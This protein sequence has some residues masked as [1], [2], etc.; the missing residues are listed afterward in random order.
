MDKMVCSQSPLCNSLINGNKSIGFPLVCLIENGHKLLTIQSP[1]CL[2]Q[3]EGKKSLSRNY[4]VFFAAKWYLVWFMI[5]SK[6]IV[7]NWMYHDIFLNW[8][9]CNFFSAIYRWVK[10]ITIFNYVSPQAYVLLVH[11]VIPRFVAHMWHIDFCQLYIFI[12]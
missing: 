7:I 1:N 9:Y 8:K 2:L 12:P 4:T 6:Y 10:H 3:N 5:I 11:P